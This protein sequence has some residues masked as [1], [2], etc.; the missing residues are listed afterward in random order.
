MCSTTPCFIYV[1]TAL[2]VQ[3]G[4]TNSLKLAVARCFAPGLISF[5]RKLRINLRIW[6]I[7]PII[8]FLHSLFFHTLFSF[9]YTYF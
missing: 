7:E 4:C 3:Q 6:I 5:H 2:N 8:K 1:T 9:L